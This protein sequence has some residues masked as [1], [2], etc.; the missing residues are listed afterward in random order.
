MYV[1]K[2]IEKEFIYESCLRSY[3]L[4]FPKKIFHL[5]NFSRDCERNGKR[6]RHF[7]ERRLEN[8]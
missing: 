1:T 4:G 3:L 7:S 8:K 6:R 2:K 5:S